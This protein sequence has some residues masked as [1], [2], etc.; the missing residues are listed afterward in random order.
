MI[1]AQTLTGRVLVSSHSSTIFCHFRSRLLLGYSNDSWQIITITP[2]FCCD[3]LPVLSFLLC[4]WFARNHDYHKI[5]CASALGEQ[6]GHAFNFLSCKLLTCISCLP[7]K[8]FRECIKVI[9]SIKSAD[10]RDKQI[11]LLWR[12]SFQNCI[13]DMKVPGLSNCLWHHD[14]ILLSL[15]C[16]ARNSPEFNFWLKKNP[17][18]FWWHLVKKLNVII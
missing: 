14:F 13:C 15:Y 6:T 8:R 10:S 17:N 7:G 11:Y 2:G 9:P 16:I 5:C 3:N 18:P 1:S 4:F 12:T